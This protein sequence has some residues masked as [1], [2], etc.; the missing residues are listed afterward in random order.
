MIVLPILLGIWL[1]RKFKLSWRL[2]IA[3]GVTF[4]ASQVLHI[5]LLFGLTALFKNATLPSPPETWTTVFNA[6]LLGLLAGAFEETAR[7][8]LFKFFLKKA[9]T[10][11]EG[12]LVGAGHGGVEAILIGVVAALTLVQ[13]VVMRGADLSA[14]GIPAAQLQAVQQQVTAFW[15]TPAYLG[16]LGL[17]ERIFAVCLH[18]CLS[19]MVLYS[20]S[21]HK[22]LWFWMALL[23]HATVDAAAVF[24]AHSLGSVAVEGLVGA[25][26]ILSLAI[27]FALRKRFPRAE[28]EIAS[29]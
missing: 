27:L 11:N 19:A 24:F 18:L 20:L 17:T 6:I 7:F 4:I 14:L 12:V 3:G 10:C 13:M 21:A 15:Q 5:P 23:W 25:M 16:F 2:F 1:I 29:A 28:Q 22:P 26:A 8:V 9:R